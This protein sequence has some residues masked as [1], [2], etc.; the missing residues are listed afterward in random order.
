M[1]NLATALTGA[2]GEH[3][4]AYQLTCLG[5]VVG[6]PRAGSPTVDLIVANADGSAAVNVQVQTTDWAM[7]ERG[8]G[9]AKAPHR[10]EFPLGPKAATSPSPNLFF[11]L[12][13]LQ[14]TRA[15]ATSPDVYVIP[16]KWIADFCA[17]W[18]DDVKRVMLHAELEL[19]EPF[20][21]NYAPLLASLGVE[22]A[23]S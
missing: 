20:K 16:S 2:A 9:D 12:V 5:L 21:N 3:F 4:V 7:R 6:L 22:T 13:D 14:S 23:D 19:V 1:P 10:V 11:A 15:L 18:V 17:D 8:R